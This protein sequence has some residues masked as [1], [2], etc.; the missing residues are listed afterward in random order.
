M[1]PL[2]P[3][4]VTALLVSQ[5]PPA[6]ARYNSYVASAKEAVKQP[7]RRFLEADDCS[8]A[9]S[10]PVHFPAHHSYAYRVV[11]TNRPGCPDPNTLS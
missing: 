6:R 5:L 3:M 11:R 4:I 9:Y 2:M 10:L 7:L 1:V 8:K